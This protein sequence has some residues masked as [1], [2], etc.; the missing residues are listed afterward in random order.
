MFVSGI[1]QHKLDDATTVLHAAVEEVLQATLAVSPSDC[2]PLLRELLEA[3]DELFEADAEHSASAS[4]IRCLTELPF[5]AAA[6]VCN[7]GTRVR[8]AQKKLD[9]ALTAASKAGVPRPALA[10][11][12]DAHRAAN[13]AIL[14]IRRLRQPFH[15]T[16][17]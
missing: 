2:E 1:V 8:T 6:S 10:A 4:A 15:V 7:Q 14:A 3:A 5:E 9:S 12:G 11:L 17:L 16:Q 13:E